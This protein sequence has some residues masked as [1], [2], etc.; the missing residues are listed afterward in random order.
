VTTHLV[1]AERVVAGGEAL[2]R[3]PDGR[4]L[5]AS[6][7][8]A[9]ET[10][11]VEITET[12]KD[13]A[14]GHVVEVHGASPDRVVEPCPNRRAGCGG[15]DWQHLAVPRQ[16]GAKTEIVLDALR[17]TARLTDPLVVTGSSVPSEGYR[18]S[19]RVVGMSDGA[20]G[21]RAERSHRTVA[22]AGCLIAHPGLVE[23]LPLLRI[24]PEVEVAL[25]VSAATGQRTASWVGGSDK[26]RGLPRSV[27]TAADAVLYEQVAGVR[28]RVSASS[29]FQSG[30][31]AAEL[32]VDA[33][34]RAAGDLTGARVVDAYGGVG[35]FAC[36]VAG[37][38]EHVVIIESSTSAAADAQANLAGRRA[39]VMRTEVGRWKAPTGQRFDVVIADPA[40]T[41]LARPGVTALAAARAPVLVL[42]SCDPVALARDARLLADQGYRF[43]RSEALDLFP[44]THHVET[45]TRFA[46]DSVSVD[47]G[48]IQAPGRSVQIP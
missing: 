13:W 29:F 1:R 3:H 37:P 14:R 35:L 5:F 42:V 21:F 19:I 41:G 46:L 28:L 33:V 38:A 7:A 11:E 26:V 47:R 44:H 15:C 39:Q 18:T 40:R 4:V 2:C 31:A 16:L 10:V 30:P 24:E 17:R 34:A 6:G 36:T 12:K 23:L 48:N 45:V 8:L 32:L 9:G 43:E 25:R 22:A 27:F 20:P